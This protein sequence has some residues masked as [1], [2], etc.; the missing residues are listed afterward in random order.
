[1]ILTLHFLIYFTIDIP[2]LSRLIRVQMLK[3][4]AKI[5]VLIHY[6]K[7]QYLN[8]IHEEKYIAKLY[9]YV[10]HHIMVQPIDG[11]SS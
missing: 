5:I 1:M 2:F 6:E 10:Y 8:H 4:S 11:G 7:D 9:M 3:W